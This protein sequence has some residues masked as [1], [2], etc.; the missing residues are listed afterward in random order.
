MNRLLSLAILAGCIG[1]GNQM[2]NDP[3]IKA[4]RRI[5]YPGGG[6]FVGPAGAGYQHGAKTE[7]FE[8]PASQAPDW[9]KPSP[10]P[11]ISYQPTKGK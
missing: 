3:S 2:P 4:E 11:K 10:V 9:A 8:G 1:C 5:E 7:K 6:G